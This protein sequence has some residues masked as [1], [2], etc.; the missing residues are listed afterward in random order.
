MLGKPF[1]SPLQIKKVTS[2]TMVDDEPP[3][4]KRRISENDEIEEDLSGPRLVF[5]APGISC[6]PRKPLIA[7]SNP[8]KAD[9]TAKQLGGGIAGYYNVLW[10]VFVKRPSHGLENSDQC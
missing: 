9:K 6:L 7:V 10:L 2:L 1:R 5:K 4:K 3:A 8:A